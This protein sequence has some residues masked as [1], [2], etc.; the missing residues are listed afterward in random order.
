MDKSEFKLLAITTI[1]LGF[2]FSFRDWGISQFNI[3][4][5]IRN[6]IL[7]TILV[8]ISIGIHEIVHKRFAKKYDAT[9]KFKT[10]NSLLF[11]AL[12]I[13]IL[14]NGYIIFA[15]VWVVVISSKYVLRPKHKFPHMGPWERAK[16]AAVGPFSNFILAL[17]AGILA[18][19]TGAFVWHKLMVINFWLA[20]MNLFPFFRVIPLT[21]MVGQGDVRAMTHK[22]KKVVWHKND[23]PYMEGEM[24]YFGSR[25][26]GTFLLTLTI[27]TAILT[28]YFNRIFLALSM[29]ILGSI[30][31]F[32]VIYHYLEPK[33]SR[34]VGK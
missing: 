3:G 18:I 13:T 2:C 27:I 28:V 26:L 29:G 17:I 8:A 15:A 4:V 31:M 6:F 24:I 19:K 5:G 14:T 7:A 25:L 32:F 11:A 34:G 22:L 12:L 16:I 9:V 30:I 1:V 23:I 10:W 20:T 21:M 33:H